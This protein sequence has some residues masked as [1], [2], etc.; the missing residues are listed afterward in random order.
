MKVPEDEKKLI[1][2]WINEA[3]LPNVSKE[4]KVKKPKDKNS[5]STCWWRTN[6]PSKII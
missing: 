2:K 5:R 6:T 3:V 1:D 4:T